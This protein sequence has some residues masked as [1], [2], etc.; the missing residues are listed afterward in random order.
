[1]SAFEPN[2]ALRAALDG[3]LEPWLMRSL[4]R[5]GAAVGRFGLVR[6]GDAVLVGIS[7]GKDSLALALLLELRRRRVKDRY[8]LGAAMA[9]WDEFP[10]P[11]AYLETLEGFFRLI[12]VPF[13]TVRGSI[14]G[15]RGSAGFS[16]YRC[17]RQRRRLVFGEALRRGF[18]VVAFGHHLDDFAQTA[19]SNLAERGVLE[20]MPPRRSWLDGSVEVVRPLMMLRE[21]SIRT[22]AARLGLPVLDAECPFK[23][24]N[25]RLELA[26]IVANL[27]KMHRLAREK[28]VEAAL[29]VTVSGEGA[30]E[31]AW[32]SA[33]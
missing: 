13:S 6:D 11:D 26:P 24:D 15:E 3:K 22:A 28:I 1:M 19:L 27:S 20:T 2:D 23:E 30:G 9:L 4:G 8:R 18:P 29:S 7:G 33:T 32:K 25:R 5:L 14:Y 31:S 10:F 12:G 21:A 17:S 16:C